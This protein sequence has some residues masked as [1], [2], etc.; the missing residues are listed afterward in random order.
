MN[1][2]LVCDDERD[3]VTALKIYLA[4]EGYNVLEAF[5]G[6]QAL[7]II[8]ENEVD[9][10]LMDVMMPVMDG[11]TA[12][13]QLRE[14]SNIPVIMLTA[15]S[16]DIDKV[17]GLGIGADDYVTKPFNPVELMARVKS[18][19]RR[20]TRLGGRAAAVN[21]ITIGGVCIN[22]DEKS[23]TL[24]GEP[25]SLTPIEYSILFMLMSNAGKVFS[26]MEI[27]RQV[28]D[29]DAYGAEKTVAVHIRHLREKIEINPA[30]P[31]YIKVIWGQGYKFEKC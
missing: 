30:D 26:S 11:I 24:D 6:Q 3:I 18:Q 17:L 5:D 8:A 25:V 16:Q 20:F 29:G 31:R 12:T 27:Y 1:T 4:A 14:H 23:V 10:V 9:L 15:K 21:S 19:L 7:D 13:A 28:W 2:V 22:D